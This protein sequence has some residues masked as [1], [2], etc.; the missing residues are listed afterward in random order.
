MQDVTILRWRSFKAVLGFFLFLFFLFF[1]GRTCSIWK[2]PGFHMGQI[3]AA[4]AGLHHSN[5]GS[6]RTFDL[7]QLVATRDPQP[8]E[9]GQGVNLYPHG[10]QLGLQPVEPQRELLSYGLFALAF[11]YIYLSSSFLQKPQ[12]K[13]TVGQKVNS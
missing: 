8:P 13:W 1:Q 7:T 10:Y 12:R 9:R 11:R 3:R 4:A 5:T 6:S 2:F